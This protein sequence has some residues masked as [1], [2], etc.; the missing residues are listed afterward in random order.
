MNTYYIN[1]VDYNIVEDVTIIASHN[2]DSGISADKVLTTAGMFDINDTFNFATVGMKGD[3]VTKNG[4]ELIGFIPSMDNL[5]GYEKYVVYS[6]LDDAVIGYKDGKFTQININNSTT[7]YKDKATLTY[8]AIKGDMELG[9]VL[10]VKMDGDA[11]DFVSYEKG[12]ID[13]PYTA[14]NGNYASYF[15][16]NSDTE[17]I[18][19]G[20][21]ASSADIK[22]GDIVYYSKDLNVVLAYDNR[23][24]GVYEKAEPN[25]D[26]PSSVVI[27]GKTYKIEGVNAFNKLSSKG[28]LNYGDT[29]TIQL[30]RNNEIADV[31]TLS[32]TTMEDVYGYVIETGIK[33][34]TASDTT[35]SVKNY[36]KIVGTD[37]SVYEYSTKENYDKLV[38]NLVKVEF[39]GGIAK[40]SYVKNSYSISGTFNWNNRKLGSYKLSDDIEILDVYLAGEENAGGYSK[41]YPQR[42]DGNKLSKDNII[43]AD[44]NADNEIEKLVLNDYTGDVYTYGLVKSADSKSTPVSITGTYT[45][46]INGAE[47]P[48]N[49][50]QKKYSVG[51]GQAA[52]FTLF[53]NGMVDTANSL[54]RIEGNVAE[55]TDTTITIN[56][57]KYKLS[58]KVIVYE[59]D[60]NYDYTIKNISEIKN[61]LSKYQIMAYCDKSQENGGRVRV[62]IVQPK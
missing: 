14:Y 6:Q 58:D 35:T 54:K 37:G 24:T 49:T 45:F 31:V 50:I 7:A 26:T 55:L 23:I 5:S 56:S 51:S 30:G 28:T 13:G 21:G 46:V 57:T 27:S 16:T 17:F 9:D 59:K 34:F 44:I 38:N 15:S 60:Y 42:I 25:K 19:N 41:V 2:E 36:A 3:I 62:L 8:S 61:N 52:K 10:Y 43:Y 12:N 20:S 4:D 32:D 33:E 11:I 48:A 39:N 47:V 40:L 1:A 53:A 29:V 22:N 18:R